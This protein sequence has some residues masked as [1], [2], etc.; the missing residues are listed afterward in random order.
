MSPYFVGIS[1]SM[2]AVGQLCLLVLKVMALCRR[3][4]VGPEAQ[5]PLSPVAGVPVWAA[6]APCGDW[7]VAATVGR[8]GRV[9][10]QRSRLRVLAAVA[11][12]A[13]VRMAGPHFSGTG[14]AAEGAGPQG[15]CAPGMSDRELLWR[16]AC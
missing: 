9:S 14:V 12:G 3:H 7:A 6:C 4:P 1:V 2:Y 13:L 16:G 15:G 5:F 10:L 8:V 11:L